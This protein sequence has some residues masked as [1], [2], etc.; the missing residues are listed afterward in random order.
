MSATRATDLRS[1]R[2]IAPV[3]R[4][5]AETA[6]AA[7]TGAPR[8]TIPADKVARVALTPAVTSSPAAVATTP[9]AVTVAQTSPI[10][11]ASERAVLAAAR[12]RDRGVG[13]LSTPAD[14]SPRPPGSRSR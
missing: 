3:R 9:A 1:E 11:P 7:A 8:P 4:A 10:P 2:A 5:L 13:L 6:G 14:R 12:R